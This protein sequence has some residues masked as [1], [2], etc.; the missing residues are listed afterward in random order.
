M[1]YVEEQH[2]R[3][4]YFFDSATI[5]RLADF[6]G[7]FER[8]CCL[9]APMVGRALHERGKSVAV[10]DVD[11]RFEDLPGFVEWDLFRPRHLSEQF[12]L[13]LVDPPFFNVSLS[14]LFTAVRLL[15]HF[16]LSQKLMIAYPVRRQA[17]LL[18]VFA[19]F[20]LSSSGWK[21]GYLTVQNCDRN[22]IEFFANVDDLP[23]RELQ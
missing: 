11:H 18:Q 17:A 23:S 3:E 10:L 15:A 7:S 9:C 6:V 2:G 20:Q 16:D 12:D 19:R 1:K 4:Q 14:Q 13:I 22:E 8:P 21:P 5:E